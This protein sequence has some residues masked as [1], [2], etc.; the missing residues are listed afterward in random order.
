MYLYRETAR[1]ILA[2]L[3]VIQQWI[4]AQPVGKPLLISKSNGNAVRNNYGLGW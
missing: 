2:I 3:A 1:E 4:L